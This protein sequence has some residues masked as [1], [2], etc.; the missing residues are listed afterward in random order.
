MV[1]LELNEN[2]T[3]EM[4]ISFFNA[5]TENLSEWKDVVSGIL[6]PYNFRK[7]YISGH[8]IFIKSIG[9]VGNTLYKKYGK[10]Y[11]KR[12][13]SLAEICFKKGVSVIAR[14]CNEWNKN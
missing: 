1:S 7:Q 10:A 5:C 11:F 2:Q 14:N 8:A 9:V 3:K 13:A 6:S 4:I 12:M